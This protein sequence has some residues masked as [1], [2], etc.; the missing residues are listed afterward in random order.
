M[1]RSTLDHLFTEKVG[2]AIGREI[3]RQ[4]LMRAKRLIEDE[5]VKIGT[6]AGICGFCNA[7]YFTN[8]FRRETGL[9]PKAWRK[10]GN[11]EVGS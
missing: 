1:P 3:L 8:V 2:H 5:S 6:I 4:R 9:S 11:F 7:S 10:K